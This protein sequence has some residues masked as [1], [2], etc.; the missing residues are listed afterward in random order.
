MCHPVHAKR[1]LEQLGR[2]FTCRKKVTG[3]PVLLCLVNIIFYLGSFCFLQ[4]EANIT[5]SGFISDS[6]GNALAGANVQ[7][8][9]LEIG[10]VSDTSG[11]YRI[12]LPAGRASGEQVEITVQYV[13]YKSRSKKVILDS[14]AHV[15]HFTLQEDLFQ[16]ETIVVTGIASKTARQF[17]AVAVSSI[18]AA[19][20][21]D[22]SDY[23]STAQLLSGKFSG[24][25]VTP[26][27]GNTGGGFRFFM[28][29]GGGLIGDEQPVIY[30]DGIRV[31]NSSI[32]GRYTAGG[33][34]MS[35]L[36]NLNP[37]DI[38]KIEVL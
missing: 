20:Y 2:I 15:V 35:I 26:A 23:Q 10:A 27:S 24:I 16:S 8:K 30:V 21:I 11:F 29:S 36:A 17:A 5:I 14:T 7:I 31:D 6:N 33:Q 25:Q 34:D 13:G 37:Q 1:I 12:I 18:D 9:Y 22:I 28:R 3:Q 32:A 38:D 19:D 4:A